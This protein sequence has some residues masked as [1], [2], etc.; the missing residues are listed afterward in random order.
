MKSLLHIASL[1]L[2]LCSCVSIQSTESSAPVAFEKIT[3]N[4]SFPAMTDFRFLPDSNDFIALNRS[5]T[6]AFFRLQKNR[7][8][9]VDS[10]VIPD[11]HTVGDC[12]A[13][14]LQLDP[15]FRENGFFYA[16]YCIDQN[17]STVVRFRFEPNA[18]S[19][20][21]QT[22]SE[23]ITEGD[24]LATRSI[25]GAAAINFDSSKA[26][27]IS[28]GEKGRGENAQNLSN[29]LGKIIRIIPSRD[30]AGA[31]YEVPGDN[32][33]AGGDPSDDKVYAYGLRNPW[34]AAFD[35]LGRYWIADV[36]SV[37]DEE[38]NVLL[39]PGLNFGWP[40]VEGK[41]ESRCEGFS[42]PTFSYSRAPNDPL[43][44]DDEL[45]DQKTRFRVA[46][47]GTEYDPSQGDRYNGLLNGKMLFGEW[48]MGW[49][50]AAKVDA[51]GVVT[52]NDFVG[53]LPFI[54]SWGQGVDRYLYA[55][56]MFGAENVDVNGV[57][58]FTDPAALNGVLW[59][60]VPREEKE[61]NML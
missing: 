32:P 6:V 1:S 15:D 61:G 51:K 23:V 20:S 28:F 19:T 17:V 41:C 48:Y 25:H 60:M 16:S 56:T 4:A 27:L 22:M 11:V 36:G 2:F 7:T 47:V 53:H 39:T 26:M 9:L 3:L 10:F 46:W 45:A 30:P 50:R 31:G 35:S 54:V 37:K 42:D 44:L 33:F 24:P 14:A 49:I 5:G 57:P 58:E 59:R 34:R 43:S 12:G 13:A 29:S 52:G 55:A 40:I 21:L 8:E 38:V 18:F